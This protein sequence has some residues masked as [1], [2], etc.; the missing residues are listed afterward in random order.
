MQ[1]SPPCPPA[2]PAKRTRIIGTL[3]F[4]IA[5]LACFAAVFTGVHSSD[6]IIAP[7]RATRSAPMKG[8][9]IKDIRYNTAPA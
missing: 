2:G 8:V 6:L 7:T 3:P 1:F 9:I 5:H 4:V